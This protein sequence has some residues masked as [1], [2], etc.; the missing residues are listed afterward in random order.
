MTAGRVFWMVG[1]MPAKTF[2]KNVIQATLYSSCNY[3]RMKRA[4]L[5]YAPTAIENPCS[6]LE[7]I[8]PRPKWARVVSSPL[9]PEKLDIT[10]I[11]P[12]YKVETYVGACLESILKQDVDASIEVIAVIDGSPDESETIV[13]RIAERDGR[14][15]VIV[16]ENRGL[17]AARNAGIALARGAWIAFVDS[18]DMLAPG[19]LAALVKRMRAG[20]CDVVASL[21]RRMDERGVVGEI[22][23]QTR[24]HMA[25]WGRL[26]KREVWEALRFPVGCWYEDLITPCCI[27]PLFHEES[28]DDAGYLYRTRPGS[29]VEESSTNVKA[30]DAYW[31][32]DEMLSWRFDL[33]CTFNHE[34]W[35]RLIWIM[36]PLTE[37]RTTFLEDGQRR[38]LFSALCDTVASL[39]E[40]SNERTTL[41]GAWQDVELALRGRHYELWCLA[42]ASL[43]K[44]SSSIKM[45]TAWKIYRASLEM[46]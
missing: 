9:P 4:A 18:D 12:I 20:G 10:V 29:I 30:L 25:P 36:G 39:E 23:E 28:I 13:R 2:L 35:D 19:H 16:Q 17:S 6:G 27:Q 42:C 3:G 45:A 26:Y 31:A 44:D 7:K 14:L 21:W 41:S 38:L 22:G 43:A 46:R 8:S 37:G 15:R 24:T 5:E 34:D 32:L 11:V 40:L 1:T 33:G